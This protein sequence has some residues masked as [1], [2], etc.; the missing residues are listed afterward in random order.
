MWLENGLPES[1]YDATAM[2]LLD[3][4]EETT[5]IEKAIKDAWGQYWPICVQS[6][7][8][9]EFESNWKAL[10]DSLT[11]AGIEQYTQIMQDNYQNQIS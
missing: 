11:A 5:M 8:D 9:A 7:S 10:Q 1:I 2:T 4:P 3:R 6:N